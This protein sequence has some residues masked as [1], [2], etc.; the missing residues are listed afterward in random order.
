[1]FKQIGSLK[2]LAFGAISLSSA[3][4]AAEQFLSP[5]N[6]SSDYTEYGFYDV[7]RSNQYNVVGSGIDSNSTNVLVYE[8]NGNL[9]YN[10]SADAGHFNSIGLSQVPQYYEFGR[11]I[12]INWGTIAAGLVV[13]NSQ[14]CAVLLGRKING[15]FESRLN[16]VIHAPD[17]CDGEYPTF[18]NHIAMTDNQMFVTGDEH[19]YIYSYNYS[20]NTWSL[21][22]TIEG[23]AAGGGEVEAHGDRVMVKVA[24]WVLGIFKKNYGNGQ[25]E[26]EHRIF[27][28]EPRTLKFDISNDRAAYTTD[29]TMRI[30]QL[31]GSS[32][33]Y[34]GEIP[35]DYPYGAAL[36]IENNIIA[37]GQANGQHLPEGGIRIFQD[38]WNGWMELNLYKHDNV[39]ETVGYA[40]EL[41][42][43]MLLASAVTADQGGFSAVGG[44][45]LT[46]LWEAINY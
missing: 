41:K 11:G 30:Y 24:S 18:G 8:N 21:S 35:G 13:Q 39:P 42:N 40:V 31:N 16:T 45:W 2:V 23:A 1:M 7:A 12:G 33:Q 5:P 14:K 6:P 20:N 38:Q 32:W 43:G 17:G 34:D 15:N 3:L 44:A 10:Y 29:T 37:V 36:A 22:Q 27:V 25:Y 9:A 46:P 19:L 28:P 26:L 4:A